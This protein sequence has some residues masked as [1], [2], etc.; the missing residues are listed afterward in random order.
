MA[1]FDAMP[2]TLR[3]ELRH[4]I[5]EWDAV[6]ILSSYRADPDEDYIIEALRKK[7]GAR[8]AGLHTADRAAAA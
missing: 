4:S 5:A 3:H 8:S 2:I 1:A 6:G 7:D